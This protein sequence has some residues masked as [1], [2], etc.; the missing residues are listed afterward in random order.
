[1]TDATPAPPRRWPLVPVFVGYLLLA[2]AAAWPLTADLGG[3]LPGDASGD[4]GIYVWNLWIFRHELLDHHAVPLWTDHILQPGSRIDLALHNYTMFQDV[5]ALALVPGLGLVAAFNVIWIGMQALGGLGAFLLARRKTARDAIAFLAGALFAFSPTMIA[6][7]TAHQSLVAAA[8]LTFFLLFVLRAADR[9]TLADA[10]LA[11]VCAAWAALCDAYYGVYCVPLLV[12]VGV[13]RLARFEPLPQR[14]GPSP[15][16]TIVTGL[17]AF[18]IVIA[19]I[20]LVTGGG[21]LELGGLTIRA[22]TLYTP[23]LAFSVLV[24]IRAWLALRGRGRWHIDGGADR[25]RLLQLAVGGAVCAALLAPVIHTARARMQA[26]GRLQEPVLWR[27]SPPGVDLLAFFVPNP[28]H[29]LAPEAFR[30]FLTTRPDSFPEN[31]ASVPYV[32]LVVIGLALARRPR[33]KTSLGLAAFFGLLALGPFITVAHLNTHIPGP[34]A[35]LRYLP[36]LGAA[37]TPAR[38]AIPM[39]IAVA[40]LFAWA[41]DRVARRRLTVGIVAGALAFELLPVPRVTASARVPVVYDTIA[42]DPDEVTVL[43]IPFGIWDGRSQTG[44]P[45]TAKMYYQTRHEKR[46]VGGYLSRVPRRRIRS[47]LSHPTLRML[48]LM[49]ERQPVDRTLAEAARQDAGSFLQKGRIRYVVIN[50]RTASPE[51]RATA[52]DLLRLR[53]VASAD[54]LELYRTDQ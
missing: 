19:A 25:F 21:R 30:D 28:N 37:R 42:S 35:L 48:T 41:M 4:T 2:F 1:M 33:P 51:L 8:P 34:W 7:S 11:G 50:S 17:M 53:L 54:G 45:N 10:A 47:Q 38:F 14:R 6:R 31:V 46:L 32:A 39:L 49:S 9:R 36:I 12:W 24:A 5:L 27:S 13:A 26:G 29:P 22:T 52:I 15:L 44:V 43:E 3:T 20:I 16:A 18:P 23:M 40:L